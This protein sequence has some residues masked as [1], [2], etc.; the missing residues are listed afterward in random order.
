MSELKINDEKNMRHA[1]K[2]LNLFL[3]KKERSYFFQGFV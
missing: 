2:A 1:L 3:S